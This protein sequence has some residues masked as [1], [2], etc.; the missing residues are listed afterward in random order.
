M[1]SMR[2]FIERARNDARERIKSSPY[3]VS[4]SAYESARGIYNAGRYNPNRLY[5]GSN[6]IPNTRPSAPVKGSSL[7]GGRPITVKG[8]VIGITRDE[9]PSGSDYIP[10]GASA[11]DKAPKEWAGA[12]NRK[13]TTRAGKSERKSVRVGSQNGGT[14]G[15]RDERPTSERYGSGIIG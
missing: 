5:A 8:V 6:D 10:D 9:L 7:N 15:E 11:A 4:L 2:E 12:W 3:N 1:E 13:N 14:R